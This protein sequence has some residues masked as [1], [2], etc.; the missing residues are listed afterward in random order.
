MIFTHKKLITLAITALH[1]WLV[2]VSLPLVSGYDLDNM[3]L[4]SEH[5]C[6]QLPLY[7]NY[8]RH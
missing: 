2:Y 4:T 5:L 6:L 8:C 3:V 7:L 1:L